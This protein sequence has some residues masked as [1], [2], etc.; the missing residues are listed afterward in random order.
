[1]SEK[2]DIL[3]AQEKERAHRV[4][5]TNISLEIIPW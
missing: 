5:K 3:T 4:N 1:M 2:Y